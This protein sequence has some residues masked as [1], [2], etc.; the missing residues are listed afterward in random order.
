[1]QK[2]LISL[3]PNWFKEIP[4]FDKILHLIVGLVIYFTFCLIIESVYALLIV[5]TVALGKELIDNRPNKESTYDFMAT[6][7]MPLLICIIEN[8]K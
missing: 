1:M 6:F 2:K 5:F 4:N 8:I 7:A 3:L